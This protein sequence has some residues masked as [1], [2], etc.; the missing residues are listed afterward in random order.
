MKFKY[1]MKVKWPL[2][3]P[4][5]HWLDQREDRAV[6][7]VLHRRSLFRYYGMKK[8]K[9]V[10][11]LEA[12]ARVFYGV[13]Y[14]LWVNSGTGALFTAITALGIGPGCEVI[15]PAFFW[16]ATAGAVVNANAIPVLCEVDDSFCMDPE[17]LAEKIT[18][19]TK[20]I[21]PVHMAGAPCD[22]KAIMA[23]AKKHG[24]PVL[25]DCAQA[26]GGS[27]RGKTLGTFGALGMFSFQWN[28][29]ATAGEG[30]LLV[31]N[32]AMLYERCNAAH[33]LGIPWV[34][35]APC[36]T[37]VVT[38]GAGRRMSEL[39][40]A[41][42]S[43]QLTKLPRIIQHMRASKMR[44][45]RILKGTPGIMFRRLNDEAGDTGPFLIF[46][47]ASAERAQAVVKRMQANG[48]T[49]AVRLADYGM[50]IYY[51]VP[52]LANKVPLSPAGNPWSL[53]QNQALVRD[54]GKGACPSSDDRFSRSCTSST[55]RASH[56]SSTRSRLVR[57]T[58]PRFTWRRSRMARCS[59][60]CGITPSSAAT[61]RRAR[62]IPP[63][64]ASMFLIKRSWPGTS[65]MLTSLPL[66][67]R[68]HAN[69]RS[70]VIPRSFSSWRRSGSMP[71]SALMSVDLP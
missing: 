39:T 35:G 57:A 18:P 5:A 20:V 21:V 24:L 9:H 65:T 38:W 66:G 26:N 50:H 6:L 13:K 54:Y 31:T 29:N 56:S 15:V 27:F 45:K 70:I 47:L 34:N 19:R 7:D 67:R 51:N 69:P 1:P 11:A 12:K 2:P 46:S 60:V 4:G 59:T 28:K 37:G 14:A 25:E 68:S 49:S 16:V 42:G 61:T 53:P 8:P 3:Y 10:E 62:S 71:V 23:I 17:D 41:V 52:Q 40:G 48:L 44:I 43:V 22:M 55:T 32:D 63:T 36:E 58:T 30:G 64:P 33:D